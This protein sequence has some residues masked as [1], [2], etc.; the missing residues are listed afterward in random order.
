MSERRQ[1]VPPGAARRRGGRRPRR[2][3]RG[4]TRGR[5]PG[6]VGAERPDGWRRPFGIESLEVVF[7]P[8]GS[9][10]GGSP[11]TGGSRSCPRWARACLGEP[12][13]GQPR[14]AK[15]LRA[16][17]LSSG[18]LDG[19]YTRAQIPKAR[20]ATLSVRT[21]WRTIE[22]PVW[23]CPA[24]PTAWRTCSARV[25]AQRGCRSRRQR[26][27]L[28]RLPAPMLG[29]VAAGASL[30]RASGTYTTSRARRTTGAL[31]GRTSDRAGARQE[32]VGQ[33]RDAA[34]PAT[35]QDKIYGTA[36]RDGGMNLA[37]QL[38]EMSHTPDNVSAYDNP[39]NEGPVGPAPGLALQQGPAVGHDD[40]PRE[41]HGL[42]RVHGRVPEREQHPDRGQ[43]RGRQG[44]GDDVDPRRPVL[45]GR[46]PEQPA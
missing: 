21:A 33:A 8:G 15:E 46:R 32:V 22:A 40:R 14:T 4:P 31:E 17:A 39:F 5:R 11:T 9:P 7:A 30:A 34:S 35:K 24:C 45:H 2:A 23:I 18:N 3:R 12:A 28:Q 13:R 43:D 19:V 27:G 42:R 37:E 29:S 26:R 36:R 6:V 16:A 38:G 41:L 10:T 1:G 20:M 44:P 25:R